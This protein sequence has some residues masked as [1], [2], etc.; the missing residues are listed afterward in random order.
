MSVTASL[1]ILDAIFS[2]TGPKKYRFCLG[3][4]GWGPFQLIGEMKSG[5]WINYGKMRL[6]QG[7]ENAKQ[8][9][10]ENQELAEEIKTKILIAKG[11]A[12]DPEQTKK[13]ASGA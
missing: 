12:E 2:E 4:A 11:L 13:D 1:D 10:K 5:A 3:Y 8:F 7:R 9:L 6:G